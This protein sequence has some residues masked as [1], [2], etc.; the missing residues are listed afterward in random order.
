VSPPLCFRP[1][2]P[3]DIGQLARLDDGWRE[4][5]L[6]Q[7]LDIAWSMV[8][9]ALLDAP[10]GDMQAGHLVG[11][12]VVWLVAD[13]L[14]LLNIAVDGPARRH[15]VGRE[16]LGRVLER[17]RAKRASVTLEVRAGNEAALRLY[18]AMG[19][20]ECGRRQGYY[21]DNAEDAILMTWREEP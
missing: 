13:E 9:V 5:A 19:F 17:A 7:E 20:R 15:G 8:E 18:R 6:A 16:L 10:L 1:A 21:Q 11:F 14:Q 2:G 3:A 4:L 12:T